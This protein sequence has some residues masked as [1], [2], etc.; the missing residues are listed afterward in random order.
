[1]AGYP[2][3]RGIVNFCV[4]LYT[5]VK[6]LTDSAEMLGE[7]PEEPSKFE[8]KVAAALHMKPDDVMMLVAVVLAVILAIGMFFVLPIG[9]E[10]LIKMALPHQDLLVNLL[11][12]LIRICVFWAISWRFRSSRRS[13]ACSSTTARST[14]P[15]IATKTTCRSPWENAQ[16]F[17]TLHPRCG[18]SF[19]VIVFLISILI[20][21]VFGTNSSNVLARVGS[22]LALLP[23]VAGV[24]Y[25]VLQTLARLP[26]N[27]LVRALSGRADDAK[28]HHQAAGRFHGGSGHPFPQGAGGHSGKGRAG[29]FAV[30]CTQAPPRTRL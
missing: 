19:L 2:I 15:C 26:R 28:D 12:G 20:F 4:M 18:T 13:G 17:P 30:R 5:G 14:R 24:S 7:E 29:G 16:K 9:L 8:K 22:R 6:I 25:E 11:G 10:T 27:R 1:M 23:V 3:I 21:T